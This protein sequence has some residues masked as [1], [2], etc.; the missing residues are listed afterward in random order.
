VAL[1]SCSGVNVAPGAS[2]Q[3]AVNAN[4]TGTIFCLAA[5]TYS[6]QTVTPKANQQF[7]C[8]DASYTCVLT[9]GSSTQ[10]AFLGPAA[11]VSIKYLKIMNYRPPLSNGAVFGYN[12]SNWT[13]YGNELTGNTPGAGTDVWTGW[14]I[15]QNYI[16]HNGQLGITGQADLVGALIDSN[17]VAYNNTGASPTDPNCCAGGIKVVRAY[18]LTLRANFVHHNGGQGMWCDFCFATT[19]YRKNRVEDNTFVGIYHEASDDAIIDSNTT[20]RNGASNRGGIWVDN[21]LNVTVAYNDVSDATSGILA[22]QVPRTD[23][24]RQLSNLSVHDNTV[25]LEGVEYAGLV[26][27]VSD[28]SYFSSKNNH[29]TCNHWTQPLSSTTDFRWNNANYTRAQWMTAGNDTSGCASFA[30]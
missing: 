3:A 2:I 12:S 27:L 7:I 5:G 1:H 17:E 14:L 26:Q 16:H 30:P 8:K 22:R 13:L 29:F 21:S 15:R 18:N 24:P 9:G 4:P 10:Y 19:K 11:G 28:N 25:V 20:R 6:N 23:T